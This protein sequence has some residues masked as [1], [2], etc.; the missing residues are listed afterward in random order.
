[1][2][3]YDHPILPFQDNP[4]AA[5]A[6][7]LRQGNGHTDM[8]EAVYRQEAALVCTLANGVLLRHTAG[9]G[10]LLSAETSS[11]L[12]RLL[13]AVP[14]DAK[15]A[16]LHQPWGLDAARSKFPD[17]ALTLR[18]LWR[19]PHLEPPR[20]SPGF[21]VWPLDEGD[22]PDSLSCDPTLPVAA[23]RT[24]IQRRRVYGAYIREQLAGTVGTAPA[25]EICYLSV[26]PDLRE[27]GIGPG[28][29]R[30][31][32]RRELQNGHVPYA[33]LE[34]ENARTAALAQQVGLEPSGGSL[35]ILEAAS[36]PLNVENP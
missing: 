14:A 26:R 29:L 13:E 19:Y 32:L 35:L 9:G 16:V 20:F 22:I 6:Y 25:G 30:W 4:S 15:R 18:E 1:M 8:T 24:Q 11:A 23:L 31:M 34:P 28:L 33:L 21:E 36:A 17:S 5:L 7:L 12:A 27:Q 2:K 10:Y 3:S